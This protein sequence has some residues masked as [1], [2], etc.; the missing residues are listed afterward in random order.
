[1]DDRVLLNTVH[2]FWEPRICTSIYI[3]YYRMGHCPSILWLI[4][5]WC[6]EIETSWQI[7]NNVLILLRPMGLNL[8]LMEM[9]A[10]SWFDHII[11]EVYDSW[12]FRLIKP[13]SAKKC[14]HLIFFLLWSTNMAKMFKSWPQQNSL[15]AGEMV[16]WRSHL[17]P[18]NYLW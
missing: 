16:R 11:S 3:I 13:K 17:P 10:W 15:D 12:K 4:W 14:V 9:R 1:M 8:H 5:K 2:F 6:V 18:T 7:V